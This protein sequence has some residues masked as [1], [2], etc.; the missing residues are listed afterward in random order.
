VAK[1][2]WTDLHETFAAAGR[3][4]TTPVVVTGGLAKRVV[5]A[6]KQRPHPIKEKERHYCYWYSP[7]R[8]DA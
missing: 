2:T 3:V 8:E 7:P 6:T 1:K 5:V 4:L